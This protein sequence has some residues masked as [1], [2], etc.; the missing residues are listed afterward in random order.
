MDQPCINCASPYIG[1]GLEIYHKED[2]EKKK[3]W[4]DPQGFR[5]VF[6]VASKTEKFSDHH[7]VG[8]D[9]SV[10]PA[11]HKFREDDKNTFLYGNFRYG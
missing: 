5:T 10:P 8:A 3:N 7:Y 1:S 6:T 2:Q 9:P 11:C 4:V